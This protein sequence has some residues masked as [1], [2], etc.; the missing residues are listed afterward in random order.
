MAKIQSI[1]YLVLF[2]SVVF[3]LNAQNKANEV[4]SNRTIC[5]KVG[6]E[7]VLTANLGKRINEKNLFI[8][9]HQMLLS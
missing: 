2:L 9:Q 4:L 5:L 8:G 6:E 1:V 3:N 7:A